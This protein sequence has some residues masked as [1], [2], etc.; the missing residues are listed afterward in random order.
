MSA[1]AS[2]RYRVLES[3]PYH[4]LLF[5]IC[6]TYEYTTGLKWQFIHFFYFISLFF[7]WM[8]HLQF[9]IAICPDSISAAAVFFVSFCFCFSWLQ[10]P[11]ACRRYQGQLILRYMVTGPDWKSA[12][13]GKKTIMYCNR[14]VKGLVS[15]L[16]PMMCMAR[17]LFIQGAEHTEFGKYLCKFSSFLNYFPLDFLVINNRFKRIFQIPYSFF[18]CLLIYCYFEVINGIGK[19]WTRYKISISSL[20][21]FFE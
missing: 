6:L 10:A 14:P 12:P 16:I 8:W 2:P 18:N 9:G 21:R 17:K 13:A 4:Y 3:K 11:T 5:Y 20:S 1:P 15:N 19:R 7:L